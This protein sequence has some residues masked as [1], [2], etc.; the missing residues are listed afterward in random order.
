MPLHSDT[1]ELLIFLRENPLIRQRIKAEPDNTLLYAGHFF[2]PIWIQIEADRKYDGLSAGKTILP[3]VLKKILLTGLP[4]RN[5]LEWVKQIDKVYPWNQNGYIAWR[6]LSGIFA[7]NATG[8][9]SFMIGSGVSKAEKKVFAATEISVL[10]RNPNIDKITKDIIQYYLKC[11]KE[12]KSDI[13]LS[14]IRA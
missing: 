7:S 6:A 4:H 9:V 3:D 13:N 12:G 5:L 1:K 11:I 14:L 2:T 8:A 10:D